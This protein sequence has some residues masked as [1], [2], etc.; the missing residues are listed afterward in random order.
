MR[1]HILTYL[2]PIILLTFLTSCSKPGFYSVIVTSDVQH[3]RN[4]SNELEE[5]YANKNVIFPASIVIMS[6]EVKNIWNDKVKD[7]T[8]HKV[9][10]SLKAI[11]GSI[12]IRASAC[13]NKG[14]AMFIH[15]DSMVKK[16]GKFIDVELRYV[17]MGDNDQMIW[18]ATEFYKIDTPD[19]CK[20]GFHTI[21]FQFVTRKFL[22]NIKS[23]KLMRVMVVC[24]D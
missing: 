14:I 16:R 2:F 12:T 11:A 8:V 1:T 21:E 19:K 9:K 13:G 3:E 15:D 24:A 18:V 7:L 10:T 17:C 22:K 23:P 4:I 6:E 20:K 5:P